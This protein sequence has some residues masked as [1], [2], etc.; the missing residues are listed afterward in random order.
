MACGLPIVTT[1]ISGVR[2][3][4][5]SSCASLTAAGDA[6]NMAEQVLSLVNDDSRLEMMSRSGRERAMEFSWPVVAGKLQDFYSGLY[7]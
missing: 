5:D 2:D 1:D 7:R 4:V 3:Y 6:G